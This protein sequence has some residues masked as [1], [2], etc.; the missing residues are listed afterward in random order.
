MYFYVIAFIF[1]IPFTIFGLLLSLLVVTPDPGLHSRLF[2]PLH[3][4][5]RALHFYR[6]KTSALSSLVDPSRNVLTRATVSALSS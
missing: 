2:S 5:V 1:S 6:Q 3:T 4:T